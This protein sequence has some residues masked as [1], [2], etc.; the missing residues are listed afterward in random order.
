MLSGVDTGYMVV[1][2]G[3]GN[4]QDCQFVKFTL[5]GVHYMAVEDPDDGYRS[6]CRDLA[7]SDEPPKYS[8]PPQTMICYMKENGDDGYANDI[9][10]MQD[11]LTGEI[12]L[13]VGTGD[14]NDY[15]PYCHLMYY[16][17]GMACN[18]PDIS[19]DAFNR[20]I[21]APIELLS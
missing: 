7:V 21:K 9:L 4:E 6:R 18:N 8:F 19:E 10:I 14:Y 13:E 2:D 12:V 5:D 3:W 11:G 1:E 20:I 15:Y 16:P 17:E